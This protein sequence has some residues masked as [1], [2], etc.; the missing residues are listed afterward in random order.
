MFT[1]KEKLFRSSAKDK[2]PKVRKI[3]MSKQ[4]SDWCNAKNR[5]IMKVLGQTPLGE[6]GC[7]GCGEEFSDSDALSLHL[8]EICP[9]IGF[10]IESSYGEALKEAMGEGRIGVKELFP[11]STDFNGLIRKQ[12]KSYG[13]RLAILPPRN[14][15]VVS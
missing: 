2:K 9:E 7:Q 15:Q 6:N 5:K 12:E 14:V 8:K 10:S 1:L 11:Y 4:N 3:S 13:T